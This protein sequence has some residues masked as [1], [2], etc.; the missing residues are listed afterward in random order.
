M[1]SEIGYVSRPEEAR[2]AGIA[3]LLLNL[4]MVLPA[5]FYITTIL[6]GQ[7]LLSTIALLAF[8]ILLADLLAYLEIRG[9]LKDMF[10]SLL[11]TVRLDKRDFRANDDLYRSIVRIAED[12]LV[13]NRITFDAR[14]EGHRFG[15]HLIP[16][17]KAFI[18]GAHGL[19]LKVR[20]GKTVA[21]VILGPVS[22]PDEPVPR[23][24]LEGLRQEL[25]RSEKET[26]SGKKG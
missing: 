24:L 22:G 3:I 5:L 18:L 26:S 25:L 7:D 8:I 2:Q 21:H 23:K 16:Y 13:R 4:I 12:N 15:G 14:S 11:F 6:H 20:R 19:T 10:D 1:I 17:S 9:F